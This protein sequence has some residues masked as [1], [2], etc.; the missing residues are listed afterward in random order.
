MKKWQGWFLSDHSAALEADA[1][2]AEGLLVRPEQSETEVGTIL[3]IALSEGL[4]VTIQL[5]ILEQ[6]RLLPDIKGYVRGYDES[7]HVV[8]ATETNRQQLIR[9]ADIRNI[10]LVDQEKWYRNG[11]DDYGIQS[12]QSVSK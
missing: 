6:D 9:V 2:Q 3:E 7:N 1:L 5:N 12:D 8:L 4:A 10:M 11:I